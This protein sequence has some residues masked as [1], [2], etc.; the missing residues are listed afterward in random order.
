MSS[1]LNNAASSGIKLALR[2]MTKLGGS[3]LLADDDRRK[4]AERLVRSTAANGYRLAATVSKR[5]FQ[6]KNVNSA[7]QRLNTV[8][9]SLFD[10]NPT[11]E[12]RMIQETC[13]DFAQEMIQPAAEACEKDRA[14]SAEIQ[15]TAAEIGLP[16]LGVP[17]EL[18]GVADSQS[19]V[20]SVLALTEL[21]EGD[22][23]IAA[24]LMS[25]TAVTTALSRYGTASQQSTFLPAFTSEEPAIGCLALLEGHPAADPLSPR[26]KAM[27]EGDT[28][29]L[30]GAKSL[31]LQ[32]EHAALF[33]VS[34]SVAGRPHLVIVEAG[35]E[36][37]SISEEPAMGIR[38]AGCQTLY[39]DQVKVPAGNILGTYEDLVDAIRRARLAWAA[40]AVGAG[41]AALKQLIPYVKERVAFGEPIA[42]R[43]AVA[44]TIS[45]IATELDG[46]ELAVWRAAA[47]L[48]AGKDAKDA[49]GRAYYLSTKYSSEIGSH[50]VQLLGGHGFV[51][52]YPNER[53]YRDLQSCAVMQGGL[54]L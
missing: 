17:A 26:T 40:C 31:A 18:G 11:D 16:L 47:Q 50:A 51:K 24:G 53:W 54:S 49:I 6:R 41:K 23:G 32:A 9:T 45:T 5:R 46:L 14:I 15:E 42:Y 19:A 38:A 34:A 10:L 44:F 20:T 43:Q 4:A 48:D 52:E 13:R 37:L 2:A 35:A 36:G 12:Q 22:M 33:I 1:Y 30:T 21:A 27:R 28:L 8:K 3:Q 39:F 7:P 25:T 29:T